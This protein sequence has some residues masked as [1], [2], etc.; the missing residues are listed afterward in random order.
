M[1]PLARSSGAPRPSLLRFPRE[2]LE[3][4][5]PEPVS[6]PPRSLGER[7]HSRVELLHDDDSTELVVVD[8]GLQDKNRS[9]V[10]IRPING[11]IAEGDLVVIG[12]EQ[13]PTASDT[14][15][16]AEADVEADVE[17]A[18]PGMMLPPGMSPPSA[19]VICV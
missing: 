2:E 10:E 11:S 12:I 18:P 8:V 3:V 4:D 15:A 17:V 16:D 7:A 14:G 1:P 5:R 13:A 19:P 6:T 9:L